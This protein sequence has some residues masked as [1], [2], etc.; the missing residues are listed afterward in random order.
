MNGER[1][2][3][4]A[5]LAATGSVEAGIDAVLR[6]HRVLW[7]AEL[8]GR[9]LHPEGHSTPN[10][11]MVETAYVRERC[12]DATMQVLLD[13][14]AKDTHP[15][16]R[17]T[18]SEVTKVVWEK[19]HCTCFKITAFQPLRVARLALGSVAPEHQL[20]FLL[21]QNIR[22]T[23]GA[24]F[25]ASAAEVLNRMAQA[26]NDL[27]Q[28]SEV[29]RLLHRRRKGSHE[30]LERDAFVDALAGAL[31]DAWVE[32][33]RGN[34]GAFSI[35]PQ[36]PRGVDERRSSLI[37]FFLELC[38]TVDYLRPA[39]QLDDLKLRAAVVDAE[40]LLS[41]LFGLSTGIPGFDELFGGGG[42]ILSQA[43]P[44]DQGY[45]PDQIDGRM[46]LIEGKSGTGKS[47]LSLQLAVEVARKGG[48]AWMLLLEQSPEEC[49]YTLESIQALPHDDSFLI[50]SDNAATVELLARKTEGKGGLVM[51]R[52]AKESFEAFVQNVLDT[53][54]E[55][56]GYPIRLIIVDPINSVVRGGGK[57]LAELRAVM[58]HALAQLRELRANVVLVAEESENRKDDLYFERN[59]ADVVIRL[60]VE[61]H[62]HYAQRYVEIA[63]S[64]LQREQ[65]GRH[66]LGIVP[67]RGIAIYPSSAAV[68][69]RIRTRA[70]REPETPILFGLP[71]V[72]RVLGPGD[73]RAGDVIVLQGPS[74]SY[75][76][77]LGLNFLLGRDL[78]RTELKPA[79][80]WVLARDNE[81]TARRLLNQGVFPPGTDKSPSDIRILA[82]P[83]GHVQPGFIFQRIENAL[84]SARREGVWIDRIMVDDVAHWELSCPFLRE[85]ET[86]G[87]TLVEFLRRHDVTSLFTCSDEI[88]DGSVLQHSILDR[89]D[90]VVVLEQFEIH[91]TRRVLMRVVRSRG[92]RHSR[93]S[94]EV[95]LRGGSLEIKPALLRVGGN[96]EVSR[97]GI[98]LFLHTESKAQDAYNE[99]LRK[100]LE[101][102]L[103][104]EIKIEPQAAYMSTVLGISSHSVVEEL[105]ILQVDEFEL[106]RL[107]GKDGGDLA[108]HQFPRERWDAEDWNGFLPALEW[109]VRTERKS[110]CA[111]PFFEN[112]SFLAYRED[113]FAPDEAQRWEQIADRCR[114]WEADHPEQDRL[115]FD[116]SKQK[117]ESYNCLFIQILAS[118]EEPPP[119][120][121]GA[122]RLVHWLQSEN[123]VRAAL[124]MRT[125]CRRSYLAEM[126]RGRRGSTGAAPLDPEA[127]VWHLWYTTVPMLAEALG[128]GGNIRKVR[129]CPAP[130]EISVAGE[131]YLAVPAY[132]AAPDVGLD[133]IKLLTRKEAEIERIRS[134]MGLPT[135]TAF[136]SG[137]GDLLLT[138]DPTLPNL[139]LPRETLK[140]LI[141]GAI[142][143]SDFGC[144]HRFTD[145]LAY[146]LQKVIEIPGDDV[147][148]HV[149]RLMGNL[150]ESFRFLSPNEPCAGCSLPKAHRWE[151]R[152]EARRS[153]T[154]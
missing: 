31:P 41:N 130:G 48:L 30:G 139:A 152:R 136:Y 129:F 112:V 93:E 2:D 90:Y 60:S 52:G 88:R 11:R 62:H 87:D 46:F 75:R 69:A 17:G 118:L 100:S 5:F 103:S 82:L 63:K 89:C 42:P 27:A 121:T 35:G 37:R 28:K 119:R 125:L 144:Y 49:M 68:S 133:I 145:S 4:A 38:T 132:S 67:G 56:E 92:M 98:R 76:T 6:L 79:S 153:R 148:D 61:E 34:P 107:A 117:N 8:A 54:A 50:A 20:R 13:L 77:R 21:M 154:K 104:G 143:R 65:R 135:R 78:S 126:E 57:H 64:R 15:M 71:S 23:Y 113:R 53:A 97:T 26:V 72:D 127:T 58:V 111:V 150:Q 140:R 115:F 131:W 1:P 19:D 99:R 124:L 29:R 122:C 9:F 16:G 18:T 149:R 73:M 36:D 47:M 66:P 33:L 102:V 85:D 44:G 86:F 39:Y 45:D 142:R 94:F 101:A 22:R 70:P 95:G 12:G 105:Q 141:S 81:V 43:Y 51:Q 3:P 137:K 108:L 110:F 10:Y 80:L 24:R 114:R 91:A 146:H 7:D 84:L 147:E 59:I 116:F 123:A 83:Q 40:Y 106:L 74:G 151:L 134:G 25:S 32:E 109:R 55:M 96:G 14:L 138:M 128:P 120:R